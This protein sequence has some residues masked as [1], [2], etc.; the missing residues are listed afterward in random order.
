MKT[1]N[2]NS[3]EKKPRHHRPASTPEGREQQI[4]ALAMDLAYERLLDGTASNQLICEIIKSASS[5]KKLKKEIM[6]AQKELLTAKTEAIHDQKDIKEMYAK[7]LT[8]MRTYSG[9]ASEEYTDDDEE[10]F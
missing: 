5:E 4:Q 8:A 10:I 9:V 3:G 2:S 7:A 1:S 6:E